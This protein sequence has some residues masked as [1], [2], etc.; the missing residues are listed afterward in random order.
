[1]DSV[2]LNSLLDLIPEERKETIYKTIQKNAILPGSR[3]GKAPMSQIL[4]SLKTNNQMQEFFLSNIFESYFPSVKLQK[5]DPEN[6]EVTEENL[7]GRLACYFYKKRGSVQEIWDSMQSEIDHYRNSLSAADPETQ[8]AEN[9]LD[10]L[11]G[12]SESEEEQETGEESIPALSDFYQTEPVTLNKLLNEA[13]V[14]MI[15][16]RDLGG[17]LWIIG[18]E[19]LKPLVERCKEI[20]VYFSFK[21]GG[22]KVCRGRDAWWTDASDPVIGKE[23]DTESGFRSVRRF[24]RIHSCKSGSE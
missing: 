24:G 7:P 9:G 15:D 20:G 10:V 1:M 2:I 8:E 22:G 16:K 13:G 21:E 18:G 12:F 17:N 3:K 6:L 23:P 5:V 19:E 14:E 4:N 11:E